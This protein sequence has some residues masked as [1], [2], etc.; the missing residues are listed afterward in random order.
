MTAGEFTFI[1][2]AGAFRFKADLVFGG[3]VYSA[4]RQLSQCRVSSLRFRRLPCIASQRLHGWCGISERRGASRILEGPDGSGGETAYGAP[5][6]PSLRVVSRTARS[7]VLELITPGFVAT[8]TPVGG[9]R[10][11]LN[12]QPLSLPVATDPI[13]ETDLVSVAARLL[14]EHLRGL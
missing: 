8:E 11:R 6:E 4:G 9:Y 1:R 14:E 2:I 12:T 10:W 3:D 13:T 5:G 7:V